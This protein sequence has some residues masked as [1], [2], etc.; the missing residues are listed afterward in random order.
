[1]PRAAKPPSSLDEVTANAIK[2][3]MV[4][5]RMAGSVVGLPAA[6][7]DGFDCLKIARAARKAQDDFRHKAKLRQ[8]REQKGERAA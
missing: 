3:E 5:Q 7:G 8:Q 6:V 4:R 1:M 2:R